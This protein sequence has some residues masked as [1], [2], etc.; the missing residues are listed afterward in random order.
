MNTI[1]NYAG[2]IFLWMSIA[3]GM[4][5]ILTL[6]YIFFVNWIGKKWKNSFMI[7]EFIIYRKEFKEWVKDKPRHKNLKSE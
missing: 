6:F 4:T 1:Y 3:I 5:F 7:L 2:F